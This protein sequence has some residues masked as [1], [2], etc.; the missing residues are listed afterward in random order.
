MVE[1]L[2]EVIDI[3]LE[4]GRLILDRQRSGFNVETKADNSPVTIADHEAEELITQR[5]SR[6]FPD[7]GI[8]GEEHGAQQGRSNRVWA[9][10]PID[11]TKAFVRGVPLFGTT[12]GLLE[13]G[14]S[15]LGVIHLPAL[16]ETI[17]AFQGHGCLWNGEAARVSSVDRLEDALML[18]CQVRGVFKLGLQKKFEDL[19]MRLRMFRT[20]ADCYGYALVATG[21]AEICFDTGAHLWDTAPLAVIVEEA[22]GHFTSLAGEPTVHGNNCLAT[23]GLLHEQVL[24]Y[25]RTDQHTDRE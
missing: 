19:L 8:I 18:S 17:A 4:A 7:D 10:D 16:N 24:N 13:D 23:N 22:G 3:A 12:I 9:I 15:I 1:L 14:K 6:S 11:G 21:R 25:L 20:W 5:L 2:A